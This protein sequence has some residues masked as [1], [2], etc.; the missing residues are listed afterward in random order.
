MQEFASST[1][2]YD[3]EDDAIDGM[4]RTAVERPTRQDAP[5]QEGPSDQSWRAL[6][7]AVPTE[8]YAEAP[9]VATSRIR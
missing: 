4:E 5:R 2:R 6:V 1:G 9:V 8:W 3:D 7:T